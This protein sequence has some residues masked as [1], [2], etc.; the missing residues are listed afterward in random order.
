[1]DPH[2][3]LLNPDQPGDIESPEAEPEPEQPRVAYLGFYLGHDIY[4]M[5]LEHLR[6]VARVAH[7]RRVPGAPAGVAGLVNLRGEIVCA[8][9]VRMIL[10][11]PEHT[12]TEPPFLVAVRGFGDPLG[13]IVDS[14]ADIYSVAAADIETAPDNWPADRTACVT[15]MARVPAGLM[16]LL[17]VAR[18]MKPIAALP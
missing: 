10:G 9:D 11:L 1:M 13:F 14:I 6:E 4:G 16:G 2:D 7:V 5:P 12:S 15:G 3:P 18:L 8:L 17:D